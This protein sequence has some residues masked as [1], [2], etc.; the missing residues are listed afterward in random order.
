RPLPHDVGVRRA[1][2]VEAVAVPILAAS[3]VLTDADLVVLAQHGSADKQQAIAG[4][5]EVSEEVA[6]ALTRQGSE[7]VVATLLA[8]ARARIAEASLAT[9]IDRFGTSERVQTNMVHRNNLP[10]TI[11][12]RLVVLASETLH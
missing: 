4:R 7:T 12:H 10:V 3:P 8:N 2:D 11:A 1:N 5:A 9:A 6:D